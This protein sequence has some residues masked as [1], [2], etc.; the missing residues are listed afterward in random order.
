MQECPP[1]GSLVVQTKG[2]CEKD[3]PSWKKRGTAGAAFAELLRKDSAYS[4]VP[5]QGI[6]AYASPIMAIIEWSFWQQR[7]GCPSLEPAARTSHFL[8]EPSL[9]PS[10]AS[11]PC[12]MRGFPTD[13]VQP[14]S[15]R[16]FAHL[17]RH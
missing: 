11:C 9:A 5:D 6:P 1:K 12:R 8:G 15:R 3:L 17:F 14:Q 2:A 16:L 10:L 13:R 7:V 4:L